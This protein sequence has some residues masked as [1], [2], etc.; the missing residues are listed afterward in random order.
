MPTNALKVKCVFVGTC[1][2]IPFDGKG[3]VKKRIENSVSVGYLCLFS[4][5]RRQ[6][7]VFFD[8][9]KTVL[10]LSQK[11]ITSL[12]KRHKVRTIRM[13]ILREILNVR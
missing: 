10:I 7:G 2:V 3:S 5:R 4:C 12:T 9:F 1:I 11:F 8:L 6:V 13:G